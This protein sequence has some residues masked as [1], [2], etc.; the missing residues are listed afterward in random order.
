MPICVFSRKWING[1][2]I[3]KRVSGVAECES[4]VCLIPSRQV[5]GQLEIKLRTNGDINA[6]Q[7]NDLQPEG[8]TLNKPRIPLSNDFSENS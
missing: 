6:K 2:T 8:M 5:E 7:S 4:E 3:K 1:K